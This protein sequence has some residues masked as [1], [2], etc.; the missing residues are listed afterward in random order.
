MSVSQEILLPRSR[1]FPKRL[2]VAL[3]AEL[4]GL[5]PR[6][7]FV[8]SVSRLLPQLAFARLRT[9]LYRFGGL[10]IGAQS[11]IFGHLNIA[12]HGNWKALVEIGR[13]TLVTG[14]LYIDLA[15]PIRI[16][17]RVRIGHQ[18]TLLT[19]THRVGPSSQRCGANVAGPIEI[20][21]GSWIASSVTI[22]P[23]VKIGA[24]A[25]VAA[26]AVVNR[27]V[28]ENTMV[29]GVPARVVQELDDGAP[30]PSSWLLR[31][32]PGPM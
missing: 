25:I 6:H 21:D 32:A 14:P 7:L 31:L 23:G 28:P 17:D 16:G 12:G 22:L 18:V 3:R 19:V 4:H 24:G 8:L 30:P 20:G 1:S 27:D 9:A 2:S 26:G 11:L 13:A 29:A 5:N 10:R 15:A